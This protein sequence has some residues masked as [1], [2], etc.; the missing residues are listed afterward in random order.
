M[1][2]ERQQEAQK[3][4]LTWGTLH[5]ALSHT[6]FLAIL[7]SLDIVAHPELPPA[8]KHGWETEKDRLVPVQTI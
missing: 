3:L 7:W 6:H 1:F 8:T 4:P 5:E 2:T